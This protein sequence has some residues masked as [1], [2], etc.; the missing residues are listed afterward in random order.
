MNALLRD[1]HSGGAGLRGT[2]G[3]GV[4]RIAEPD[5]NDM[6]ASAA[7]SA[8]GLKVE[9]QNGNR[10]LARLGALH[11]TVFLP[12]DTDL[13]RSPS[14]TFELG[15]IAVAWALK[16]MLKQ[17]FVRIQG[18]QVAVDLAAVPALAPYRELLQYIRRVDMTT[19]A[20]VL[21]VRFHVAIG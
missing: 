1:L 12:P 6:L 11:A 21:T 17:A 3:E 15:S 13:S 8:A 2:A 16:R 10:V 19:A 5:L 20:G 9:I 7:G 4:V 18:R 14:L